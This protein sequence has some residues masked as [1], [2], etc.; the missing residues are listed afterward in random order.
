MLVASASSHHLCQFG[1]APRETA[2]DAA[3]QGLALAVLLVRVHPA[4]PEVGG[5]H[6]VAVERR[7][8]A[9]VPQAR[10]IW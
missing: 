4:A 2:Q 1:V 7:G 6:V 5:L 9:G 8:Q 3:L 10:M